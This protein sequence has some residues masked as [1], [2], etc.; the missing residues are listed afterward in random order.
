MFFR[1]VTHVTL[2]RPGCV[3]APPFDSRFHT[4]SLARGTSV[5]NASRKRMIGIGAAW[6]AAY[7]LVLNV[8]L[9]SVLYAAAVSPLSW[10]DGHILCANSA[11][12]SV[13]R[14]DAGKS[15]KRA[16]G[17]CPLC[18]GN[19][20]ADALPSPPSPVT[21]ERVPSRTAAVI[22]LDTV[23]VSLSRISDHRARGPPSLI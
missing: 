21:I 4:G 15:D 5:N 8:I 19:H 22:A 16:S 9:S 10:A 7:A 6:L 23:F 1:V 13:V 12:I 18:L 20:A 17:H 11:D 3:S 2:F 14:D